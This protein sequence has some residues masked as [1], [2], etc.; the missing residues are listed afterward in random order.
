MRKTFVTVWLAALCMSA[1]EDFQSTLPSALR[2]P[3]T[4][5][6][7]FQMHGV[8]DQV[9]SCKAVEGKY[10]WTLKAP[11][12]QLLDSQGHVFGHHFAGPTWEAEDGSD[13]VGKSAA[14]VPSPD[15]SSVPWLRLDA[16]RH[17]G[18][19]KMTQVVSI[20]R[21]NTKG[22]KAPTDGCDSSHVGV[23]TRAHYEADY[24]FYSNAG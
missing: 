12:A 10:A 7:L 3:A 13:V 8:G 22:G 6:L 23:E 18:N 1:Q 14:S 21:L 20:Q 5:K 24:Y 16:I 11:D 4:Q 17:E 15:P 2:V 9:Y 19:G